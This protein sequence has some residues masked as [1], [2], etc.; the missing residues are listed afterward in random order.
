M[1]VVAEAQVGVEGCVLAPLEVGRRYR[2]IG[3]NPLAKPESAGKSTSGWWE[4]SECVV[5]GIKDGWYTV[6]GKGLTAKVI[7]FGCEKFWRP[8][9]EGRLM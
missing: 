2:A 4:P 6:E 5:T 1:G 8:V 7:K 9:D 3:P